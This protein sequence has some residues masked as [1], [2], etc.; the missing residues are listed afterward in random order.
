MEIKT[1]EQYVL[2]Q[3]HDTMNKLDEADRNNEFLMKKL[4]EKNAD[5]AQLRE[6]IK[7]FSRINIF[8]GSTNFEFSVSNA[9]YCSQEERDAFD[10]LCELFPDTPERDYRKQKTEVRTAEGDIA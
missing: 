1:C 10:M 9:T 3:L 8:D 5:I 2:A 4:E 7:T 6:F